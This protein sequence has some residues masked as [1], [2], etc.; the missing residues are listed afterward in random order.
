MCSGTHRASN[1][2]DAKRQ[3]GELMNQY[4]IGFSHIARNGDDLFWIK[5]AGSP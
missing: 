1:Q 5:G 4:R 2:L 3:D